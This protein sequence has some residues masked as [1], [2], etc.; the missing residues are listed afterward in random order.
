MTKLQMMTEKQQLVL[1]IMR[2][3]YLVHENTSYC[4]FIRYSGHVDELQVEIRRSKDIWQEKLFQVELVDHY[5]ERKNEGSRYPQ[6]DATVALLENI[7][8]DG[9]IDF[10]EVGEY[11]I[12]YDV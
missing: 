4:A 7:L 11:E 6:L 10:D 2:L 9:R 12:R 8:R 5:T 3:A 1:R